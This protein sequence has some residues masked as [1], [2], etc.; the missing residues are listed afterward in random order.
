MFQYMNYP[1]GE[2]SIWI[3]NY[4]EIY[5]VDQRQVILNVTYSLISGIVLNLVSALEY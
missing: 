2:G 3:I 5:S 4:P 1:S